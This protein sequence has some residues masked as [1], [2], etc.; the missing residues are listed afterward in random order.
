MDKDMIG[1]NQNV[2]RKFSSKEIGFLDGQLLGDQAKIDA[3]FSIIELF[4]EVNG[5]N[6]FCVTGSKR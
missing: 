5:K 2:W 3:L 4:M 6:H 1:G